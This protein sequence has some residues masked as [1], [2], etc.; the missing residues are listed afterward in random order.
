MAVAVTIPE[1]APSPEADRRDTPVVTSMPRIDAS[2]AA[3]SRPTSVPDFDVEAFAGASLRHPHASSVPLDLAIPTRRP[4]PPDAA[5]DLRSAFL[6]L[7]VDGRSSIAEIAHYVSL[8]IAEVVPRILSLVAIGAVEL[9]GPSA[10]RT[11]TV[12]VSGIVGR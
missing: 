1:S 4:L 11:S 3:S 9:I 6:Y 7:H 10:D 2:T 12:P 8:P 5:L